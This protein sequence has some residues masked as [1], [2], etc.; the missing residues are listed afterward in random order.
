[1]QSSSEH[2]WQRRGGLK[3][4][5]WLQSGPVLAWVSSNPLSLLNSWLQPLQL[6]LPAL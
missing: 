3:I 2:S 1:M 6:Q 5:V 4:S